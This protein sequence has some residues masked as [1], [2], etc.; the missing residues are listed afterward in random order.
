MDNQYYYHSIRKTS[1]QI[2]DLFNNIQVA[3]YNDN[4]SI[5]KVIKVPL[6]YSPKDKFTYWLFHQK[7]HEKRLPIMGLALTSIE[8]D[9]SRLKNNTTPITYLIDDEFMRHMNPTPYN[10]HYKLHIASQYIVEADQILEQILPFFD[11]NIFVRVDLPEFNNKYN[12]KVTLDSIAQANT[13][14][15]PLDDNRLVLWEL[16]FTAQSYI[17]KPTTNSEV[18]KKIINRYYDNQNSFSEMKKIN[19]AVTDSLPLSANH[20]FDTKTLFLSGAMINGL[21]EVTQYEE[22]DGD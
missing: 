12:V 6:R 4:G 13:P 2:L 3:K 15:T 22:F 17:F 18:I 1:V 9:V 7:K 10:M 14:D 20:D 8:F 16:D 19:P 11:P 21:V 5:N